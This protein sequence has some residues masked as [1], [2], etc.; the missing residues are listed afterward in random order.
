MNKKLNNII[1]YPE[2]IPCDKRIHFIV[3]VV[4]M[5]ILTVF[6]TNVFIVNITLVSVAW[7]IE[8]SQKYTKSGQFDNYDAI[9]VMVGG[10]VVYLSHIL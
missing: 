2:K 8:Y 1:R 7:G 3:G 5:A 6:T 9:A 4:L 10:L